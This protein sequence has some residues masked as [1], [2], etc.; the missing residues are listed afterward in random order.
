LPPRLP[1]GNENTTAAVNQRLQVLRDQ[2]IELPEVSNPATLI[3]P[4]SL[5]SNIENLVGCARLPLGVIG[6]LRINGFHAHGD[7]YVPLATSEGA[8]VASY[9]RGAYLIGQAG[10]AAVAALTESV[11]RAPAFVFQGLS[12]SLRFLAW[13]LE[14]LDTWKE[15]AGEL[16]NHCELID[17]QPTVAGKDL[18]LNLV[19]RTGEAAGQNMVTLVTEEICRRMVAAAPLQPQHWYVEGNLSGDKKATMHSF[20][21]ARGKKVV[22]ETT[23]PAGLV[24]RFLH[25]SPQNMMDYWEI[26]I[27]GGTQSGSIGVQGHY[28]NALAAL[29]AACGQDIACVAE[30]AVGLTRLDVTAAGDLYV[31]VSLPNVIVGTVGGGTGL[32]TAQECLKMMGCA[33][34]GAAL[35]LAE[36]CGATAL[37]GEISIIGSLAAGDFAAAHRTYGRRSKRDGS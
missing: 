32:P 17:L 35:K 36:I 19:Y 26:S 14:K 18:F 6:P 5:E 30:A 29:F 31:S 9:N 33:G 2:G 23:L 8:L 22:A 13:A 21:Q 4:A 10:G 34:P 28:A 27:M 24:E 7:F 37:A 12:E 11:S 3:D 20:I 16:S 1:A 15:V 25:T